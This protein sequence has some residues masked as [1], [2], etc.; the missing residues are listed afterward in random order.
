[1]GL[2]SFERDVSFSC[3]QSYQSFCAK[4]RAKHVAQLVS[5]FFMEPASCEQQTYKSLGLAE[6]M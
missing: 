1:M 6:M 3:Y 2:S 4:H 5:S